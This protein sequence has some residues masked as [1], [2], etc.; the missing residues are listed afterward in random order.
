VLQG[1]LDRLKGAAPRENLGETERKLEEAKKT[2]RENN[3]KCPKTV[4]PQGASD[5]LMDM[6]KYKEEYKTWG[7]YINGLLLFAEF[8]NEEGEI[9]SGGMIKYLKWF[10]SKATGVYEQIL[11]SEKSVMENW[12]EAIVNAPNK[13]RAELDNVFFIE[14][15]F[16]IV[17]SAEQMKKL[18]D[19]YNDANR[20]FNGEERTQYG[21]IKAELE[22]ISNALKVLPSVA[23][24]NLSKYDGGSIKGGDS[25]MWIYDK[26]E[27]KLKRENLSA[28][29]MEPVL[30][31]ISKSH[32]FVSQA[33]GLIIW[34]NKSWA[35][36]HPQ[37]PF[38]LRY[39][40]DETR[41][42]FKQFIPKVPPKDKPMAPP[43]SDWQ[44]V[45]GGI[46]S[47][48]VGNR[49][50]KPEVP[51]ITFWQI[52]GNLPPPLV[53]LVVNFNHFIRPTVKDLFAKK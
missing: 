30:F 18:I 9:S 3:M 25:Q 24:V 5:W 51:P 32:V 20:F 53:L 6:K 13:G 26:F 22:T 27:G 52:K 12:K 34:N 19:V 49:T 42:V 46:R 4:P 1:A 40:W 28:E 16:P 35:W 38:I 14:D 39:E 7:P 41:K 43:L 50:P 23:N 29:V 33:F 15:S 21:E 2:F 47:V 48:V 37:C 45:E 8:H 44:F 11:Q 17:E 31:D 36:T 10:S